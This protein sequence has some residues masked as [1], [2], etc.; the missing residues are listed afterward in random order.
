MGANHRIHIGPVVVVKGAC[1]GWD[2]FIEK[3]GEELS[4]FHDGNGSLPKDRCFFVANV[5]YEGE[6]EIPKAAGF[7]GWL[8]LEGLDPSGEVLRFKDSFMEVLDA[9][10]ETFEEVSV[11]WGVLGGWA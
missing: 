11:E 5:P 10:E 2:D 6:P 7:C 9:M 3:Y 1:E 4:L 8:E